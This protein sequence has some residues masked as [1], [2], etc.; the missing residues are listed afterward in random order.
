LLGIANK[1]LGIGA[2]SI[3]GGNGESVIKWVGE[4]R[5]FNEQFEGWFRS[6]SRTSAVV[7]T[8]IAPF[9]AALAVEAHWVKSYLLYLN[10]DTLRR[11]IPSPA[12]AAEWVARL[13]PGTQDKRMDLVKGAVA[14]VVM[15]LLDALE[16]AII[17]FI[18]PGLTNEV[19]GSSPDLFLG[20][21]TFTVAL[22]IKIHLTSI[23]Q[24]KITLPSFKDTSSLLDKVNIKLRES[25]ISDDVEGC[26][27]L[28]YSILISSLTK[29]LREA[30]INLD[31]SNSRSNHQSC[32][33]ELIE[34]ESKPTTINFGNV[35][36][37]VGN[38]LGLNEKVQQ[39]QQQQQQQQQTPS[40]QLTPLAQQMFE[41]NWPSIEDLQNIFGGNEALFPMGGSGFDMFASFQSPQ[42]WDFASFGTT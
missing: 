27:C 31:N 34:D 4:V 1:G 28:R 8:H 19:V 20:M 3:E 12:V 11:M 39:P 9:F 29:V 35:N 25:A 24:W 22:L 2:P 18:S 36:G 26:L 42:A 16:E 21:V 32:G 37:V 17:S 13:P 23:L 33:A 5:K 14:T 6:F 38:G 10:V 30:E 41:V 15:I 40:R 7:P